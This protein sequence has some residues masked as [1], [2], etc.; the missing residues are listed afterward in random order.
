M[1]QSTPFP[2]STPATDSSLP[3]TGG[4]DHAPAR[5]SAE[6]GRPSVFDTPPD[7]P[8]CVSFPMTL[9]E[10]ERNDERLE[11]W[12]AR[13]ETAWKLRDYV[14]AHHEHP[15]TRLAVLAGRLASV[16]GSPIECL[17]TVSLIRREATGRLRWVMQ[18]DQVVYLDWARSR[19]AGRVV[20]V[21]EDALPDVV[22]E[23]DHTTDV[24]RWKLKLYQECG[25]PEL[26]VS[27]P[28]ETSVRKPGLTIHL[29]EG[30]GYRVSGESRAFPGW[31]VE[32]IHRA[33]T[34]APL[35]GKVWRA[36][37]RVGRAMGAREGTGPDDDPLTR[38]LTAS[39]RKE[40]RSEGF[41]DGRSEGFTDGRSEGFTEGRSEGFTEGRAEGR[42]AG[43]RG[44][45][46]AERVDA[47]RAVL[48][49]RGIEPAAGFAEEPE[50]LAAPP[51]E[52]VLAAALACTDEADFRRRLHDP[53]AHPLP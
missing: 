5:P 25:F 28:H 50:L 3:R 2:Q 48:R 35:S 8:G 42:T 41:T 46:L 52:A 32:E 30:D 17:G 10:Y 53:S 49:S 7:I 27:V 26:W 45:R 23:V 19:P 37:E 14:T 1:P 38:S 34:E 20:R 4:A 40:G 21:G 39:A 24:R 18:P 33:L 11:F 29:R 31:R 44:G 16:R 43:C 12:D 13:R 36:L 22:L 6:S 51:L 15:L 9:R 47:V